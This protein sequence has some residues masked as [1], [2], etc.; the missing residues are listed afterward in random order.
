MKK[1][2]LILLALWVFITM[3][4]VGWHLWNYMRLLNKEKYYQGETVK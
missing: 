1:I 4:F 3:T 2:S